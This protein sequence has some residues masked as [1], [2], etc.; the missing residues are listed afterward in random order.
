MKNQRGL[1]L[2][3]AGGHDSGLQRPADARTTNLQTEKTS[4]MILTFLITIRS[5]PYMWNYFTYD[6][7]IIAI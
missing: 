5:M 6:P 1:A 3:L 2:V 7:Y 4:Y